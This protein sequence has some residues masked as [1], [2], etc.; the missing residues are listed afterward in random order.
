MVKKTRNRLFHRGGDT[1]EERI[2][3]DKP[4][5]LNIRSMFQTNNDQTKEKEIPKANNVARL[6]QNFEDT[7]K[8]S[9]PPAKG[10]PYKNQNVHAIAARNSN[11]GGKKRKSV[12]K[13]KM[14][15]KKSLKKRKLSK[16]R[17]SLKKR[18]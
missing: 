6:R 11:L 17:K 4:S 2:V 5:F 7:N 12:K 1:K 14:A 18:R 15:K 16:K 9:E 8:E 3:F 13:R 10:M